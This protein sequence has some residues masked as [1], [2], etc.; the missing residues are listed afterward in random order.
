MT[1]ARWKWTPVLREGPVS[2]PDS[3]LAEL[4]SGHQPGS[5]S[6]SERAAIYARTS[7]P[8][9]V[10]G[11]SLDEQ[12]RQCWQRC[13]M[14]GWEVTNVF[15]DEAES[16]K[17]TERPMF[18][19]MER[20]SEQDQFDVIVFWKLDRLSRSIMHA[21]Q[22]E[23]QFRELGIALHSVTE[24]LDTTTAAG[25]FNFRNI[26]NAAEFERDLIKQRT[27]MGFKALA[28]EGK[29]PNDTPPLGY[30]KRDDDRLEVLDEEAQLVRE[31]FDAYIEARSMP[32]VAF[33]LNA[34]G[35]TTKDGNEWTAR[36]VRDVLGNEIYIGV[37][38]VSGVEEAAEEYAIVD[39]EVF[40]RVQEVRH[41]FQRGRDAKRERMPEDRKAT[42]VDAVTEQYLDYLDAG[43]D[44]S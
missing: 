12:V 44:S 37:Y 33:D 19:V 15:R 2:K 17:D 27:Q 42:H 30:R 8:N 18:Q 28:L 24:Q 14:V 29:W 31:I 5:D 34:R 1:Y 10:F 41:R 35:I 13:E 20:K 36:A 32:Q 25:R 16:A 7:S 22:L 21:V 9:Q 6:S 26:A 3:V 38:S 11:R 23:H 40:E 43:A 4:L 39:E